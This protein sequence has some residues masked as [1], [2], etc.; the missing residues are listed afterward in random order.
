[1]R[2]NR[3]A[4]N[5][6]VFNL[7]A[8]STRA[9]ERFSF[10]NVTAINNTAGVSGGVLYVEDTASIPAAAYRL[11]LINVSFDGN[12]AYSG[13]GGG[14]YWVS[15]LKASRDMPLIQAAFPILIAQDLTCANNQASGNGGCLSVEGMDVVAVALNASNNRAGGEGGAGYLSRASLAIQGGVVADNFAQLAGGGIRASR[16]SSTGLSFADS[17]FIGNA[18]GCTASSCGG[19]AAAVSSCQFVVTASSFH[20]HQAGEGGAFLIDALASLE[21]YQAVCKETVQLTQAEPL[22]LRAAQLS[23]SPTLRSC[24]ILRGQLVVPSP[25]A[26]LPQS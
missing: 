16:C 3:A 13:S 21:L 23:P 7:L 25:S 1:M 11:R 12:T 17:R 24:R 20:S 15:R 5:G 4:G 10:H 26:T 2:D 14:I 19:G 18:V 22:H 6:G 9:I 8:A